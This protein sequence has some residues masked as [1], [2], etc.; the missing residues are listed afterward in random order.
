MNTNW[1]LCKTE[2]KAK[3]EKK[4]KPT[5]KSVTKRAKDTIAVLV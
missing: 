2:R 5:K 3:N 1:E 4:K